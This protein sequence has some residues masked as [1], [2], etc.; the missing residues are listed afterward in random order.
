MRPQDFRSDRTLPLV[1]TLIVISV[2]VMTFDIRS[3]G[4]GVIESFRVGVNRLLGPLER[5]GSMVVDPLADFVDG[6]ADITDLRAENE[7]LRA[8]L[9][10]SQAELA[11]VG[12]LL[13]RLESLEQLLDLQ[14]AVTAFRQTPANVIGRTSGLDLSFRIDKGEESGVLPGQPVL[15]PNGYLV[16]RV[17]DS[18]QGG[19]SIIPLVGDVDAVTVTV[20]DQVGTLSAVLGSET[21]ILDVFET[22]RPVRAGDRVVT[23][24][25]S[26]AFPPS[27]P[28]G[29]IVADADPRGQAL[30]ALVRPFAQPQRLRAVV[31]VAWPP[32]PG[33]SGDSPAGAGP[34]PT[35]PGSSG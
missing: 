14:L 17:L 9:A 12:D 28:V 13:D 10:E 1:I 4:E 34:G 22:A 27:I 18:W 2:L 20:G 5:L 29:E 19:A 6:L 3:R 15:D 8:R 23:S 11:A 32:D 31:V 35:I 33:A 24:S 21:L 25:F 30:T 7:S 16:G 26:A